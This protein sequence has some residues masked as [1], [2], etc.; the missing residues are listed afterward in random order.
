M[1]TDRDARL[2]TDYEQAGFGRRLGFGIRPAVLV[3][4]MV[5][6][7]LDP[8]S[9][10]YADVDSAVSATTALLSAARAAGVPIIFT[11]VVYQDGPRDGGLFFK[12]A[13]GLSLFVGE[14]ELGDLADELV[15]SDSELL[16]CK[17]FASAFFGT[18]LTQVLHNLGVDTVLIAGL[19]TSGCVRATAVDAVQLGFAPMVIREAVGDRDSRPHEASLFDLDAKYADVVTLDATIAYLA[20][21]HKRGT[22]D[23]T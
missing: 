8:A 10:L 16:I 3:V 13:Q 14:T 1:T 22:S 23:A 15:R 4:D 11:K 17:Q 19:S 5:K 20:A 6:A 9:P 2:V 7:Y 12:K 18:T 21:L